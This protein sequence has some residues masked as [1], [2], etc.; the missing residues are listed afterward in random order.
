MKLKASRSCFSTFPPK[1]QLVLDKILVG[2]GRGK[3]CICQWV[4]DKARH[5]DCVK[6]NQ[7][8]T[9]GGCPDSNGA[10]WFSCA[11]LRGKLI[12]VQN[13]A[14]CSA[15]AVSPSHR[16]AAPPIRLTWMH[17]WEMWCVHVCMHTLLDSALFCSI[18]LLLQENIICKHAEF[19]NRESPLCT[20]NTVLIIINVNR[21][22]F[23]F[24]FF[25]FYN[26]LDLG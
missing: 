22:V 1:T 23:F 10:N 8:V 17:A 11:D 18:H 21:S 15:G 26:S 7:L 3:V 14:G 4:V 13:A 20:Q 12:H 6:T 2:V 25:V 24:V 5:L 16:P 9:S 19:D